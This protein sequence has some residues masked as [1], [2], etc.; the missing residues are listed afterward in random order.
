MFSSGTQNI[1]SAPFSLSSRAQR[2]M[3]FA[4]LWSSK[5]ADSIRLMR[6]PYSGQLCIVSLFFLILSVEWMSSWARRM[7][8]L[9]CKLYMSVVRISV[10]STCRFEITLVLDSNV[11]SYLFLSDTPH[12]IHLRGECGKREHFSRPFITLRGIRQTKCHCVSHR[13]SRSMNKQHKS[14]KKTEMI[15][16]ECIDETKLKQFN[17]VDG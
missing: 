9:W 5:V 11:I 15:K 14:S 4:R 3:S 8:H 7:T 6:K 12:S 13:F 17:Q 10:T 16:P 2:M 1:S